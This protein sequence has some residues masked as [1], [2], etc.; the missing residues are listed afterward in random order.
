[1]FY[2]LNRILVCAEAAKKDLLHYFPAQRQAAAGQTFPELRQGFILLKFTVVKEFIQ[3]YD[4]GNLFLAGGSAF[5]SWF[6]KAPG[7]DTLSR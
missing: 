4:K 3:G 7:K 2:G 1:M 6:N 5:F